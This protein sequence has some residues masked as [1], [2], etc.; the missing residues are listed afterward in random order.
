[1]SELSWKE[2]LSGGPAPQNKKEFFI[3]MAKGL[4]MGAAD[5]IPGV[6]G[7][8]VAFITGIYTNLV[9]AITS[10]NKEVITK[11]LKFQ[12]KD[13][14]SQIHLGFLI[15]LMAG[16]FC[17]IVGLARIMHYLMREQ[18]IPTWGMFFGLILASIIIV[19]RHGEIWRDFKRIVWLVFGVLSAHFIVNLIPVQTPE[20]MWFIFLCGI[21][22]IMAMILPGISGSF[23]LLILGKYEFVTGAVKN[24]FILENIKIIIVFACGAF[25]GLTSFSR[26]LS[27]FLTKYEK[28]TMAYLTGIMIGALQKVWPWRQIVDSTVIRGKTYILKEINILP[29]NFDSI[30]ISAFVL[31]LVGIIF[32]LFLDS[33]TRKKDSMTHSS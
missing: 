10:I 33:M 7:G 32:V 24:P 22:A 20:E 4:C 8:T 29:N 31:M 26:V 23:L 6:S 28:I 27:Y 3:L 25:I 19:G 15:P 1:M 14:L 21:I 18:A 30:D 5:L 17:S 9:N 12:I 13:A 11:L 16:I 2:T